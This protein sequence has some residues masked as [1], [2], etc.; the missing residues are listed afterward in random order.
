MWRRI[1][2]AFLCLLMLGLP[3][4]AA[5]EADYQIVQGT[6]VA[7]GAYPWFAA[8]LFDGGQGCGGS[9]VAPNYVLTAAHCVIDGR[10]QPSV[11][12][13]NVSFRVNSISASAGGEVLTAAEIIPHPNYDP[14]LT[15]N[16]VALVR[17]NEAATVAPVTL[18]GQANLNLNDPPTVARVIGHG[19]IRTDGPSSD[20]LL[21]VAVDVVNDADCRASGY[22]QLVDANMVCAGNPTTDSNNPGRDSCQGDSG[23]PLFADVNG[24]PVQF[25]VVSF[26]GECGV[27]A[28]GVYSQVT[29]YF[30]WINGIVGG[31][32]Q[33]GMPDPGP[34]GQQPTGA[35]ADPVRIAGPDGNDPVGNAIAMSQLVFQGDD[36]VFGVLAASSN[37]PDALGGSAL[38]SYFGPL[39]YVDGQGQLGQQTLI[40]FQRT[41]PDGGTIYIL[42][43]TAVVAATT[44]AQLTAAGFTPVRLGGAGRQQTAALVAQEVLDTVNDG[45]GTPFD[46]AIVAFEGNWPDAV[47]VAQISAWF[48]I[49]ILLTP[50]ASL[51][52]PASEYLQANQPSLVY[53]LGGDAVVSEN[54]VAEIEAITGAGSTFRLGGTGRFETSAQMTL[55]NRFELFPLNNDV[56]EFEGEA[57]TEPDIIV[58]VNLRRDDAFTHV[59]AASMIVGNFGGVFAPVETD[60]G[61]PISQ[62]VL[63]SV[64]GLNAEVLVIGSTDLVAD[65]RIAPLQQA[66]A[67][68]GCAVG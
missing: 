42:G 58:A 46:A 55:E 59:L 30:E 8:F 44:E 12:P 2:P 35:A 20:A 22:G 17:T 49:P 34:A 9:V 18:A 45:Q 5:E 63:D 14:V 37:F 53:V 64:C 50:T 47:A 1:F 15:N 41:V 19:A 39:L 65:S 54:T 52:G 61:V 38:A 11:G 25:G 57:P 27:N 13:A 36:A 26:G 23:G 48:G 32:L 66:S 3:P 56:F 21:E 28:P 31:T 68:Q 29:T 24:T 67:G 16:D 6:P 40:E 60:G 10:G 51:G 43:G 4:A 7:A 62:A 33:P